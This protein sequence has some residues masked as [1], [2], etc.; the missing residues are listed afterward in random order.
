MNKA[1]PYHNLRTVATSADYSLM[2]TLRA[3]QTARM[4]AM[5]IVRAKFSGHFVP[6]T[7]TPLEAPEYVSHSSRFFAELGL[8]DELALEQSFNRYFLVISRP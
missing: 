2:N 8:S 1:L 7:P 3:D 5:I 4:T 6:V